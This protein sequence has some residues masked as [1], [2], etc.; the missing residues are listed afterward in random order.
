MFHLVQTTS[1]LMYERCETCRTYIPSNGNDRSI[2]I[3]YGIAQSNNHTK[4]MY[5][6]LHIRYV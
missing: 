3:G 1:H 6:N 4:Q 5:L 2:I